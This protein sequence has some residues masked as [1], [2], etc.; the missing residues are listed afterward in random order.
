MLR[1]LF[2]VSNVEDRGTVRRTWVCLCRLDISDMFS[3]L[4]LSSGS[5]DRKIEIFVWLPDGIR[6]TVRVDPE[7]LVHR[8]LTRL[9][10]EIDLPFVR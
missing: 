9:Y 2:H 6:H 1:T 3:T 10:K 7:H 5:H 8:L 4:T